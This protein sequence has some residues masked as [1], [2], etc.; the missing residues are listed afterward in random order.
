[1]TCKMTLYVKR[2][3]PYK[4]TNCKVHRN[5]TLT[6]LTR[7]QAVLTVDTTAST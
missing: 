3:Y 5:G 4:P 1:M 2:V 7:G 6:V